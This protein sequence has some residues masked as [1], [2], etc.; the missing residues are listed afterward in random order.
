M[1]FPAGGLSA[2]DEVQLLGAV[3]FIGKPFKVGALIDAIERY[4][5]PAA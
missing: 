1:A 5:L 4:A 3:A 2:H